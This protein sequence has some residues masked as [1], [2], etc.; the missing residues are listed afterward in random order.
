MDN[1]FVAIPG[2]RYAVEKD[3][4]RTLT[5]MF[6]TLIAVGICGNTK[7]WYDFSVWRNLEKTSY[8]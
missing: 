3:A 2:A 8:A 4:A 6:L 5:Q 7:I 1:N